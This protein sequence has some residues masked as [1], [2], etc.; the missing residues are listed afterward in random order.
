VKEV[1]FRGKK[2]SAGIGH[3]VEIK[4]NKISPDI[5]KVADGVSVAAIN[6]KNEIYLA[7]Q[8]RFAAKRVTYE[9]PGGGVDEDENPLDAAKRELEEEIGIQANKINYLFKA[10]PSPAFDVHTV[11]A[12]FATGIIDT[13]QNLDEDEDIHIIKMD[14]NKFYEK[15][16]KEEV[17][18]DMVTIAVLNKIKNI[19]S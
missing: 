6:D 12:Y 9:L 7:K 10:F 19:V 14:F 4:G 8:Y 13:H 15:V 2:I 11:Y 16:E 3:E 1:I 18:T 17:E 5:M